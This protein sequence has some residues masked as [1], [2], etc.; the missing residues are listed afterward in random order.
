MFYFLLIHSPASTQCPF[1]FCVSALLLCFLHASCKIS[2]VTHSGMAYTVTLLGFSVPISLFNSQLCAHF[3]L[4]NKQHFYI[5]IFIVP[6][7]LCSRDSDDFIQ[8]QFQRCQR[9]WLPGSL[10]CISMTHL[11]KQIR[12]KGSFLHY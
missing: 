8:V 1:T 6:L 10:G 9:G 12:D 7:C 4:Q 2:T 5:L 3:I 11:K